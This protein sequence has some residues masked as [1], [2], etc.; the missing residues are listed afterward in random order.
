MDVIGFI[1][2]MLLPASIAVVFAMGMLDDQ[3]PEEVA[4]A[5]I[6]YTD[7]EVDI[8]EA[9]DVLHA[10]DKQLDLTPEMAQTLD[11][12]WD[13]FNH[14]YKM[15]GRWYYDINST[16]AEIEKEQLISC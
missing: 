9:L 5:K 12:H 16:M 3:Q 11:K 10:I 14:C 8:P 2:L 4:K 6:E 1:A 15:D 7:V 13:W